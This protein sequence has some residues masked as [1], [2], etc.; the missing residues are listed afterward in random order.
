[1]T[2]KKSHFVEVRPS[3]A[4]LTNLSGAQER[5]QDVQNLTQSTVPGRVGETEVREDVH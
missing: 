4:W 1:M 3:L 5:F 2:V